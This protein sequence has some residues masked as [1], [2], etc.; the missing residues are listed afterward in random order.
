M[1]KPTQTP[2]V[3]ERSPKPDKTIADGTKD[4]DAALD[5]ALE[6]TF[7]ASDPIAMNQPHREPAKDNSKD[8]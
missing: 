7:P 3:S 2:H 4:Q 6:E 5:E 1:K 8:N